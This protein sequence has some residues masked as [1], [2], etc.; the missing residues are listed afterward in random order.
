MNDATMSELPIATLKDTLAYEYSWLAPKFQE[1]YALSRSEAEDVFLETK[2]WLWLVAYAYTTPGSPVPLTVIGL[3]QL[4][5]VD[6][7]WHSFMLF[8]QAYA[9][10]C[11]TYFGWFLHH[12]PT[13]STER[14]QLQAE[15]QS[16]P[17]AF[18]QARIAEFRVQARFVGA[19]LG[20]PT[21]RK[22]FC[23]YAEKYSPAELDRLWRPRVR[24][25]SGSAE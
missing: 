23:D 14:E 7:M 24:V 12:M 9:Q 15:R 13:T 2:R 19:T 11:E 8:T 1:R 6:E 22:W 20:A 3:P 5:I 17:V 18:E 16:D 21:V 25:A 4:T 10:F